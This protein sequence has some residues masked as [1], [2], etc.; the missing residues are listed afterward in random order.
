ML[1]LVVLSFLFMYVY[2]AYYEEIAAR[3]ILE[4][5]TDPQAT[6][7]AG[8]NTYLRGKSLA[9]IRRLM[10]AKLEEKPEHRDAPVVSQVL[11]VPPSFASGKDKWTSCATTI[12]FIKDQADCGSCWAVAASEVVEDRICIAN[13]PNTPEAKLNE[14][15]PAI[16]F[17]AEDILSCCGSSCGDGCD[18][19]FPLDAMM[20]WKQQGVVTGAWYGSNCGCYPYQVPP[21]GPN[22]C[23]GPEVPT[24]KCN[25]NCRS[26]FPRSYTQDKHK[27]TSAYKVAGNAAAI[28]TE[29]YTNG[30]VECAFTVY[31][32][33]MNYKSGVYNKQSGSVL[34]GHAVKILGW[35]TSG[36]QPY[37]IIN[38]SWN[39]TWGMNGV[40]WFLRGKNLCGM[41]AQC[42][43][44]MGV[45]GDTNVNL[46]C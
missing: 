27:A 18:G 45:K 6:W 7:T 9:Q 32:N 44:G 2:A 12:N 19:G 29:I 34:G 26:G 15:P 43:A 25:K 20:Y 39:V 33:F 13:A 37:W 41:E 10:G 40:F 17:S 36:S 38:N 14:P 24:P 4:Q 3:T 23:S 28:Q 11:A 31:E 30:P 22:G 16:S 46:Q 1:K 8:Y 5:N 35:G 21:C 42:V